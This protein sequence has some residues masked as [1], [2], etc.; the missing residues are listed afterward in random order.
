MDYLPIWGR[1]LLKRS[2]LYD[3]WNDPTY[4]ILLLFGLVISPAVGRNACKMVLS[5]TFHFDSMLLSPQFSL[6][7]DQVDHI[8]PWKICWNKD[9]SLDNSTTFLGC[10]KLKPSLGLS[11]PSQSFDHLASTSIEL[12][13]PSAQDS[14]KSMDKLMQKLKVFLWLFCH[15]SPKNRWSSYQ[16]PAMWYFPMLLYSPKFLIAVDVDS[17]C[18]KK[19]CTKCCPFLFTG[20]FCLFGDK[21]RHLWLFSTLLFSTV[22]FLFLG[23]F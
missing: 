20:S 21:Y 12:I 16:K 4:S 13:A 18:K 7:D 11:I 10:F 22:L 23:R 9:V 2:F 14:K 8:S 1:C 17:F 19:W 3:W 6:W 5:S 15:L